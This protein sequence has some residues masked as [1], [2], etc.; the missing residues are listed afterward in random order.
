MPLFLL[1][2]FDHSFESHFV[3]W[4]N[5]FYLEDAVIIHNIK[6]H[7][8]LVHRFATLATRMEQYIQGQ[9]RDLVDQAYTQFVSIYSFADSYVLACCNITCVYI[10]MS[11]MA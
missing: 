9:T 1:E 3:N 6:P 8:Y 4:C 5:A 7:I 11:A 2:M 10:I